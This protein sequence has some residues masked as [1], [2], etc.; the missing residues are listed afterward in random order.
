[1]QNSKT[2]NENNFI[3]KNKINLCHVQGQENKD[4]EF[5]KKDNR[6]GEEDVKVEEEES[7]DAMKIEIERIDEEKGKDKE[8]E[9]NGIEISRKEVGG[10]I[11]ENTDVIKEEGSADLM[12]SKI[13]PRM[14][15]FLSF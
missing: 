6:C 1:M 14:K 12:K 7:D 4:S 2:S 8:I 10:M 5:L 15:V 3:L 9:R 13:Q 11:N